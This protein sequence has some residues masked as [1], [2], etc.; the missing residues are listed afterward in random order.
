MGGGVTWLE[1]GFATML[2]YMESRL[3]CEPRT[4]KDRLRVAEALEQLPAI[5]KAL[6]EGRLLVERGPR[7]H[8]R[9]DSEDGSGMDRRRRR[10][11]RSRPAGAGGRAR[12]RRSLHRRA[13]RR[14]SRPRDHARAHAGGVRAAAASA[15]CVLEDETGGSLSDDALVEALCRRALDGKR[16]RA[17]H[18]IAVTT[19]R[20][21]ER[22]WSSGGER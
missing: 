9:R 8:V 19:C 6:F 5:A 7:D 21:C 18:Q 20:H 1:L 17:A 11:D 22:G 13:A 14:G 2:A 10:Q 4:A 15:R 3:G 16:E 12:G